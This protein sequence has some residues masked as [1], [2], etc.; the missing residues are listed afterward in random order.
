M[1]KL[2][3]LGT[4]VAL[5][6]VMAAIAVP[7]FAQVTV[8]IT[9]PASGTVGT[10]VTI[11]AS[12]S[13]PNGMSGWYVYVDNNAAWN[14]PGPTS[15]ISAPLSL[16]VG[17]H[18][19][20]VRAWD[21]K[22]YYNDA[23]LSLNVVKSGTTVSLSA[24]ANGATVS[25]PVTFTA[26]G[27][28]PNG[29]SGW[30]VYCDY[31][32][33]YQVNNGS[34]SLTASVN[35]STGTHACFV[36][37]WDNVSGYGTSATVSINVG[38]TQGTSVTVQSPSPGASVT[39]PVTFTAS[40]S[41]PN[42]ISG[43][44]I[45]ANDQNVYQVDNYSS[46]LSA[47]VNLSPGTYNVYIRAWDRVSGYGTSAPMQITVGGT[48]GLPTPP[49]DAVVLSHIEDSTG[50]WGQTSAEAG[51]LNVTTDFWMAP[52]Q[53]SP[54]LDG[55]S[56]EFYVGGPVWTA[57]LWYHPVQSYTGQYNSATH[58]LWDFWVYVDSSSM[59][60]VWTLEFDLY[61][62]ISGYEYM[63]GSHCQFSSTQQGNYWYGWNQVT[64]QWIQT[65]VPCSRNLMP[66]GQWH[67]I[68]WMMERIPNSHYYKY[69]TL[70]VNGT[71]YP[72]NMTQPAD[73]SGWG[74]T[75]GVQWQVDTN[76]NGGSVHMWTDKVTLTMW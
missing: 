29:I 23:G 16:S 58:F 49:S 13:S 73:W 26:S 43:W 60:N 1:H 7:A 15:S 9:S 21:N 45:Y 47:S 51:P 4:T 5:C 74:D 57:A 36:R 67:H 52:F 18:Y 8:K 10:A 63:I 48:S 6:F 66:G 30:V 31:N 55:S 3:S 37:A 44:V 75:L 46:S 42:G 34:N 35:L 76:A 39:S 61:Q 14:T 65:S 70:V 41:S 17:T 71:V 59:Q 68:Q 32:N 19:V 33:V 12:A 28:S 22:G 72:I 40:A 50:S 27:S 11:N 25:S 69:D 64:H 56:R 54:S 2:V 24:P 53:T 20:I 38:Q 62:A